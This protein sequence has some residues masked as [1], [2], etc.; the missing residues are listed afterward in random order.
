[1]RDGDAIPDFK[2][3]LVSE[4]EFYVEATTAGDESTIR[5][6]NKLPDMSARLDSWAMADA[7]VQV[8]LRNTQVA[9]TP[10]RMFTARQEQPAIEEMQR[11]ILS[12]NLDDYKDGFGIKIDS[13]NV[14][15][16][17][18]AQVIVSVARDSSY[19]SV[20]INSPACSFS[21]GDE[22]RNILVAVQKKI[23]N[24][25]TTFRPIRLVV[26]LQH[27]I[28]HTADVFAGIRASLKDLGP[29]ERIYF[30]NSTAALV[31]T[32]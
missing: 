8:R 12:E 23:A 6:E 5:Q 15:T 4:E 19:I 1:L 28:G 31:A 25:Y 27:V 24:E 30:A 17:T 22:Q 3:R 13:K 32:R 18:A 26:A 2:V 9:F 16:L 29:F 14:P 20:S 7:D 10:Q 11:F 21:P